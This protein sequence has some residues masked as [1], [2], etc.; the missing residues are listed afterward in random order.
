ML[1][2]ES[3][4]DIPNVYKENCKPLMSEIK[5]ELSKCRDIPCSWIRR[6]NIVTKAALPNSTRR[7]GII[8]I[9]TPAGELPPA[10]T[11]FL[12]LSGSRTVRHSTFL[13]TKSH[14]V[15]SILPQQF[16]RRI[17]GSSRWCSPPLKTTKPETSL[18]F[19]PGGR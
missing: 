6:L 4:E 16:Q 5:E 1:R 10:S 17:R 7:F 11:L 18:S 12:G 8:P 19:A 13:W 2:Y 14:P 3:K 15:Y 9:E